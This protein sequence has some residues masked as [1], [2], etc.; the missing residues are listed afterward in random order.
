MRKIILASQSPR[1]IEMLSSY[2]KE[3][4]VYA[5]DTEETVDEND[6]PETTV[7]KIALEKALKVADLCTEKGIIIA[8]D[9]V[10]YL[11]KIMGKPKDYYDGLEML[12]I[13][14]GKRHS[15]FTGVCIIDNENN[16]KVI[17]YEETFVEFNE[18]SDDFIRKYL[19]TGEYKDKAGAYGIQGYGELL[20]K[21]INGCYNNVKGLPLV[22]LNNLLTKHFSHNL[23]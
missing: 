15:V 2:V 21:G 20:V 9:T 17:D 11:N 22:K 1:R 5:P 13:L 14:S 8:A 6:L 23:L 7:M 4:S 18:L 10:V 3:L 19:E 12:K 16:K